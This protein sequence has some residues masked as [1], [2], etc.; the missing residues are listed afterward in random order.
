MKQSHKFITLFIAVFLMVASGTAMAQRGGGINRKP[1]G[2]ADRPRAQMQ[3]QRIPDLTDEQQAQIKDLRIDHM[4][5]MTR[6]R[7]KLAEKRASLRGSQTQDDPDMNTI[8]T[9]IEEMGQVRIRMHKAQAAHHQKIRNTLT[10]EQRA[11]FDA[12]QMKRRGRPG[13]HCY[14]RGN[15]PF[16]ARP[17]GPQNPWF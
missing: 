17:R 7:N 1:L 4:Q 16:R 11:I 2:R 13:S 12:R 8:N 6:F 15:R 10:E 5:E 9:T 14:N 3:Y